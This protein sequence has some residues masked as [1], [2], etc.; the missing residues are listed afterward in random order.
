MPEPGSKRGR[1]FRLWTIVLAALLLCGGIGALVLR[2][3]LQPERLTA[4]LVAQVR[5]ATDA[6]LV[7]GAPA[8]FGF[9]TTLHL[10]LPHPQLKG[11]GATAAFLRADSLEAVMPWRSV[12]SGRYEIERIDLLAPSLDLDALSAWLAT[13]PPTRHA[14]PD[15]RFALHVDRGTLVH[16]GKPIAEGLRMDF[17]S[18]GDVATWLTKFDPQSGAASLLPPLAGS[19]DAASVQIGSTRL[20]GV[21]VEMHDGTA[22]PRP[23]KP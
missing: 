10:V 8:G 4:L 17:A 11:A 9:L 19:A 6:D 13:L 16:G 22:N 20:E 3:Y 18:T 14:P 15:V 5:D 1:R 2:H 23:S 21:H 12:W 7:V